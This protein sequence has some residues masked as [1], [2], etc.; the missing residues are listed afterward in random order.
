MSISLTEIIIAL[1]PFIASAITWMVYRKFS[2]KQKQNETNLMSFDTLKTMV[3]GQSQLLKDTQ[4]RAAESTER[5]REK[6]DKY[7]AHIE[8][9][10]A[11]IVELHTNLLEK[12]IECG[13][14]KLE[15]QKNK[16]NFCIWRC[17]DKKCGSRE[18]KP[19]V[20]LSSLA[21]PE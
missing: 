12:E 15:A 16:Q 5:Y 19:E 8:E 6:Q 21:I 4:D 14:L 3:E 11:K 20:D 18:P 10:S 17:Y 13:E 2:K 9:L 7:E 1:I